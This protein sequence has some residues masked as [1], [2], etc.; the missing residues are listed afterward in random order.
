MTQSNEA[1]WS[2]GIARRFRRRFADGVWRQEAVEVVVEFPLTLFVN[3]QEFVTAVITPTDVREWVLGFLASEGLIQTP[4]DLTVFQYRPAEGQVW[5]RIP[6]LGPNGLARFGRRALGSCC[7]QGRSALHL[8][9]DAEI[10]RPLHHAIGPSLQPAM[11]IPLFEKLSGWSRTQHTGGLHAAALCLDGGL[12][13]LRADVGRHNALDKIHGHCLEKPLP[14]ERGLILFSGRLSSEIVVKIAKIGCP[15]VVSNA[16]PT[17][18][19]LDVADSL[20]ITAIGFA[21][22]G[23]FSVYTHPHRL[24][25]AWA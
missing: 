7:G 13:V 15:V 10:A 16:A 12:S 2:D 11:V 14:T 24:G 21:R 20:G 23:E 17:S 1:S 18:L 6:S 5:V 19:G 4:S 25:Q 3:G 22:D 8:A 9:S